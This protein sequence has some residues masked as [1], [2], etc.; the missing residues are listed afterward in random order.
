MNQK[1]IIIGVSHHN[2]LSMI[3]SVGHEGIKPC[4]ILYGHAN[5]YIKYSKYISAYIYVETA[6]EAVDALASLCIRTKNKPVVISCTDEISMILDQRFD[7][8]CKLCTFFNAGEKGRVSHFMD[9]QQQ[10][11]LAKDCGFKTPW[12]IECL[13]K[14]V[15]YDDV[16]YPCIVK[17]KESVHG[18]KKLFICN[19]ITELKDCLQ[20]F[21][22]R[23]SV[24]IQ[25]YI[26]GDYEVVIIGLTVN[27]LTIIPGFAKKR[28]EYKGA[29]TFSTI[30]SASEIID[31]VISA[32][33]N[34]VNQIKYEGLW[35]IEC[36]KMDECFYFI[37][38]NLRNDATTYSMTVAGVNLPY[39]Y[40][41]SKI[42]KD[43]T[44]VINKKVEKI[45][46]IVE[47][48]DF[49][50]VLKRTVSLV[51][52]KNELKGCLCRYYQD[53]EDM[54]PF[55][56]KRREYICFLFKRAFHRT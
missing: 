29:T 7:E 24:L 36:I 43:I 14:D 32:A 56:A 16:K 35:G 37:E 19:S 26:K 2:T 3:R 34:M 50:F 55:R 44:E 45:D 51:R 47:F 49:N 33:N 6:I 46:S 23:F 41:Q 25:Q 18:G 17:P 4:V 38:L 27:G 22:P 10:T 39:A 12:S 8:M 21:D 1:L 40:Y 13:P 28:R 48:D 20:R 5:S 9:K 31:S 52:W 15:P 30:Y 42:G 53:K 11:I 54:A